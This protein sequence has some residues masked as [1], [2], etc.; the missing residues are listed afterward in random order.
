V[1]RV[2]R[3]VRS[4]ERRLIVVLASLPPILSDDVSRN[5]AP[6][7]FPLRFEFLVRVVILPNAESVAE[8]A[9]EEIA[10]TVRR[11]P[12]SVLGLATGGTP[13]GAYQRLIEICNESKLTFKNVVTFNLDEYLGLAPTHPASYRR[14]MN[15]HLF[16]HLDISID[17]THVPLGDSDDIEAE[18]QAY[19]SKIHKAGGIDLQL[20]GIGTDGHIGFNEPGSSLASRTRVKTLTSQTRRDNARFFAS[21]DEVPTSAITV[22]LQTI[23]E[24]R[25]ILL[26]ATGIGKAEAIRATIE[27]PLCSAVPASALQLHANTTI[28]VDESAA[29]KLQRS[30]YY[31]QAEL[32]RRRLRKKTT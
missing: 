29:T 22:G 11:N 4:A 17:Q 15:D 24:S 16:E 10:A 23:L 27:G 7:L 30:D 6:R 18:C 21:P 14:Y 28:A 5:E 2:H 12:A 9:A 3:F 31:R 1:K 25:C 8:F 26:L 19:E 20:L 13:L 32:E